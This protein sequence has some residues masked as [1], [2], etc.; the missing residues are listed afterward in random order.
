MGRTSSGI[1]IRLVCLGLCL[2]A[3]QNPPRVTLLPVAGP[4]AGR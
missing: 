3:R 4:G 1:I 2:Q